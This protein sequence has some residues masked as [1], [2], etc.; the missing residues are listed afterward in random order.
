MACANISSLGKI[1]NKETFDTVLK[2]AIWSPVQVNV[3]AWYLDLME[4]P[5]AKTAA[6]ITLQKIENMVL[7]RE[8]APGIVGSPRNG[9][10]CILAA[11]VWLKMCQKYFNSGTVKEACEA[12]VVRAKQL[13]HVLMGQKYLSRASSKVDKTPG[14]ATKGKKQKSTATHTAVKEPEAEK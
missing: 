6:E 3:P 1:A 10:T 14:L 5:K 12:F 8:D 11:T 9:P 2:A 13:S 7:P 4:D